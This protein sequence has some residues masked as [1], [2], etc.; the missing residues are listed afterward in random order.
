MK[1]LG[2]AAVV[3]GP[4]GGGVAIGG[5][6]EQVVAGDGHRRG[7]VDSDQVGPGVE[8]CE[9][10][11]LG[12]GPVVGGF[13]CLVT[14]GVEQFQPDGFGGATGGCGRDAVCGRAR[15]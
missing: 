14:A 7:R 9:A 6:D 10:D 3:T 13:E 4:I 15:G 5:I 12:S 8:S 1:R 2:L 11:L